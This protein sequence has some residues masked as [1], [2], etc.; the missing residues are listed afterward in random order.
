MLTRATRVF[1]GKMELPD[2]RASARRRAWMP[3]LLGTVRTEQRAAKRYP[4]DMDLTYT[5]SVRG[6]TVDSGC[7]C[8]IDFSSDSL[9]FKGER[10]IRVGRGLELAIHWP[11]ALGDGVPLKLVVCAKTVRTDGDE[12]AVR[13]VSYEFRTRGAHR[14]AIGREDQVPLPAAA[15][16]ALPICE[17]SPGIYGAGSMRASFGS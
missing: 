1:G 5:V 16:T 17:R 12:T 7:G 3:K 14:R 8:T 15:A 9:R 11:V 2:R 4:L 10:P 6:Q 13:I